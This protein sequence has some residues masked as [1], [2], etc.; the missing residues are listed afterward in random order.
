MCS[1]IDDES[2][3]RDMFNQTAPETEVALVALMAVD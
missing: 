3:K 1:T 2:I